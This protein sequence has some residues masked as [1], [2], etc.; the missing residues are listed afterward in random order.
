MAQEP[1]DYTTPS[2]CT[3]LPV[4]VR[5][6]GPEVGSRRA[7]M[8]IATA[9]KWVNGTKLKYYFFN[10]PT[11]GSPVSWNGTPAQENVVRKQFEKWMGIGI[12]ISFE[13]T[14][15]KNEAQ[16]RIGF[17]KGDGSWSYIGR[18]II[19][20]ASSPDERTMNFGWD[21]SSEPDTP[22]HEIGHTLGAAHEHQNPF[23]GIVWDEPAVYA[24]LAKPPNSWSKQTTFENILQKYTP[25]DVEG[26]EHDPNS[27]MEYP[28]GPGMILSPVQYKNGIYPKGGLSEKDITFMKKYYPTLTASDYVQIKVS[29]SQALNIK[30][31]EQKNFTFKPI[32]SR[33]YNI[34]TFGTMDTV[35][36]LNEKTSTEEVYLAGDDDSGTDSN[37][38]I[39][40]R[41]IKGREYIIRVRLF[42]AD[43]EGT[44]SVMVY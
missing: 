13:E 1:A 5:T 43:G 40:L 33:K 31:G 34:E 11:D 26:T 30:A 2:Y 3:L 4:P 8:I 35:M 6:F 7:E 9:K 42:Y 22:L 12:G 36:V 20:Y 21:I 41:L 15:D 23:A 16:I 10:G 19:D 18:D 28:F 25:N 32:R 14:K 37:S 24:S 17:L 39:T 38:K 27:I 29:E 44:G